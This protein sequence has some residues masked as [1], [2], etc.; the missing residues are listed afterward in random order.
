MNHTVIL[1]LHHRPPISY[2]DVQFYCSVYTS[3]W[4]C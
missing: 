3:E 4:D 1:S 2:N